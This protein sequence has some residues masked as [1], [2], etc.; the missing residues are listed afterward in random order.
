MSASICG[1]SLDTRRL[2]LLTGF[3]L[4]AWSADRFVNGASSIARISGISP[5]VFGLTIVA[6]GTSLPELTASIAGAIKRE[7]D[8][9][10]GN[11]LG[12]NMIIIL[13]VLCM[14]ALI[15]SGPFGAAVLNRDIPVMFALS[16]V[17]LV[18]AF[19]S[20]SRGCI[21]RFEGVLLFCGFAAY[22]LLLAGEGKLLS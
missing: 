13:A 22:L 18:T 19:G 7:P 8:I 16:I 2:A 12:S 15:A 3:I 21:N 17:L 5:M 1:G 4:L 14:P 20:G 10:I 11:V 6:I 9:A